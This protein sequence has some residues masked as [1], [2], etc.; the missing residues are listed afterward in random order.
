MI[1]RYARTTLVWKAQARALSKVRTL[2]GA[3]PHAACP[4]ARLTAPR[5]PEQDSGEPRGW[6]PAAARDAKKRKQQEFAKELRAHK[7]LVAQLPPKVRMP[8][9]SAGGGGGGAGGVL[10]PT[11]VRAHATAGLALRPAG[12]HASFEGGWRQ[13]VWRCHFHSFLWY[14]WVSAVGLAS[15]ASACVDIVGPA[16]SALRRLPAPGVQL[17]S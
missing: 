13:V 9:S 17:G 11:R 15:F 1:G 10:V 4:D 2:A 5:A 7:Q 14:C 3:C 6:C 8:C 16:H 12:A